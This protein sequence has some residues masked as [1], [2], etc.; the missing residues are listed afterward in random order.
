MRLY[1]RVFRKTLANQCVKFYFQQP[2][3]WLVLIVFPSKA[4][5]QEFTLTHSDA[6]RIVI[7]RKIA[8]VHFVQKRRAPLQIYI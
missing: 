2:S 6:R 1:L 8:L 7:L 5:Y 4:G 3:H